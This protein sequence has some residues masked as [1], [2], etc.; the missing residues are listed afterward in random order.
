MMNKEMKECFEE[1]E[2]EPSDLLN[3]EDVSFS[4]S[5]FV[6]PDSDSDNFEEEF[7]KGIWLTVLINTDYQVFSKY[8]YSIRE[9]K[10]GKIV[11]E[12][13][14]IN[15]RFMSIVDESKIVFIS[16]ALAV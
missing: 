10:T 7:N 14:E 15:D 6:Q 2:F 9:R 11:K 16:D 1:K 3:I 12:N 8:P 13:P 5:D 4:E